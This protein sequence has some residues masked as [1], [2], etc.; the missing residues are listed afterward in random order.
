MLLLYIYSHEPLTS[1][2]FLLLV[3]CL[4][5]LSTLRAAGQ[6]CPRLGQS[7]QSAFPVCG[8]KNLAQ[9]SVPLCA[10][11]VLSLNLCGTVDPDTDYTDRNPFYYKFTC[12]QSGTL[13]FT[14]LPNDLADDYDWHVF[15]VTGRNVNDIFTDRSM[16]ICGNWSAHP[17]RTG[18]SAAG[19]GSFIARDSAIPTSVKCRCCRQGTSICCW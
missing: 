11:R 2:R 12:Y 8:T 16:Q 13:G 19:R 18:A 15:D 7:P 4:P 10:G 9:S 3:I 1:M 17:G 5:L 6:A 14:I